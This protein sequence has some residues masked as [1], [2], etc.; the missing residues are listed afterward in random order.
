MKSRK[1]TH[2]K[3]R[4]KIQFLIGILLLSLTIG[5]TVT[6]SFADQDI[7]ALLTN[8]FKKGTDNSIQQ[9]ESA[10]MSE[11]EVQKQRLREELQKEMNKSQK[12]L[13]HFTEQEKRKRVQ[14]IQK[15]ANELKKNIKV[16][17]KEETDRIS[18]TLD[19]IVQQSIDELN[20][21]E[22][23]TESSN[24][25]EQS[26]NGNGN[27]NDNNNKPE[28]KPQNNKDKKEEVDN[29]SNQ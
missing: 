1:L 9:I 14:E 15:Y 23:T 19:A 24:K 5:S 27:N 10:I 7:N 18:A 13:D 25:E 16:D 28:D 17:N 3:K 21:V 2:K 29:E 12:E 20:K 26:S 6:V 22:T 11:K 8:W 4:K